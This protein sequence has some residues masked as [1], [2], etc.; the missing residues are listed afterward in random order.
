MRWAAEVKFLP[1][2]G[3]AENNKSQTILLRGQFR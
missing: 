3:K 1:E 2:I